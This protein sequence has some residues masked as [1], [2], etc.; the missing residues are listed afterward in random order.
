MHWALFFHNGFAIHGTDYIRTLGLPASH[1]CVRLHPRNAATL[2]ALVNK[3]GAQRT[4]ITLYGTPRWGAP[5]RSRARVAGYSRRSR[6][7]FGGGF[8]SY[9]N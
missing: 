8:G 7:N 1:G 9:S 3:H 5:V 2:F 4:R 6:G